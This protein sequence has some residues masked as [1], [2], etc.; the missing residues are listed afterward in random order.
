[1]QGTT[2]LSFHLVEELIG[3]DGGKRT[4]LE[5][6]FDISGFHSNVFGGVETV[7]PRLCACGSGEVTLH[8]FQLRGLA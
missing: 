6:V 4:K 5:T 8:Y 3:S 1:M 2:G 7:W